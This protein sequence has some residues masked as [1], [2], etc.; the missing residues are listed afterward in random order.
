MVSRKFALTVPDSARSTQPYFMEKPLKGDIYDW[1]GVPAA[2]RGL[3]FQP[4]LV[5]ARIGFGVAGGHGTLDREVTYRVNDQAVGE[6]RKAVRVVPAIDVRLTPDRVIWPSDGDSTRSFAVTLTY[7]GST[8]RDGMVRVTAPGWPV[9]APVRFS[10]EHTGERHT[11]GFT[12]TRPRAPKDSTVQVRAV[13]ETDD[14]HSFAESVPVIDYPHIRPTPYVARAESEIRLAALRLAQ[15]RNVGYIRGAS[16]RVPEALEAVGLP[17]TV[18]SGADLASA[19][20]SRFDVLVVG[21]RA[22]E[23]DS[24]LIRHNDRVLEYAKK[25]GLVV[26]QYQQYA[27][28]RGNYAALPLTIA[29]PHDRVTD[30]NAP[31]K[32]LDP[33]DRSFHRPNDIVPGDWAGWP[34]ERGL[35][36]AHEW[37]K[38]YKPLLEMNDPGMPPLDGGLLVGKYGEGTYVYSGLAFFRFLPAGVPGAFKLFMNLLSLNARDAS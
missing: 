37:D 4:P 8:K 36:F 33:N 14:G 21:S 17:V 1:S 18:L 11:F 28:V 6:I 23:T 13:A 12:I 10:L 31:V 27:Y 7:N 24:A 16:D 30:E 35:Y 9:S 32:I 20:L 25:G 38:A 22:Y 2:V 34:Q 26:V 15:V 3:P 19:D 5:N 29:Q